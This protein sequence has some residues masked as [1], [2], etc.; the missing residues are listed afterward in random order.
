MA[1]ALGLKESPWSLGGAP[2]FKEGPLGGFLALR[3]TLGLKEGP[4]R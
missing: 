2:G 3:R 4:L 1:L